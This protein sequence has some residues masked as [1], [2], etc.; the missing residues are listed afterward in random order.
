MIVHAMK[1]VS[2]SRLVRKDLGEHALGAELHHAERMLID[3]EVQLVGAYRRWRA[4][5]KLA[6]AESPR[7]AR[8]VEESTWDLT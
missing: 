3:A 6:A 2:R 7:A 1:Y 5:M 4:L 8:Y